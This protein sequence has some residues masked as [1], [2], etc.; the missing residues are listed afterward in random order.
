MNLQEMRHQFDDLLPTWWTRHPPVRN[1]DPKDPR[2]AD[3]I[4]A[5]DGGVPVT[6]A[7]FK[8]IPD[9]ADFVP[10]YLWL[11]TS[12]PGADASYRAN[13]IIHR[14]TIFSA[15][16]RYQATNDPNPLRAQLTPLIERNPVV[17]LEEALVFL[18]N[19]N[20][21]VLNDR[22]FQDVIEIFW[23][24]P[25][26]LANPA[27]L[28]AVQTWVTDVLEP[29]APEYESAAAAARKRAAFSARWATATAA[30]TAAREALWSQIR[31]RHQVLHEEILATAWNPDR[32][33]WISWCCDMDER[34]GLRSRWD[35][36][37]AC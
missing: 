18:R 24:P 36:V 5:R 6:A 33:E 35:H 17:T 14:R 29:W 9:D 21:V 31:E 22:Q 23:S 2:V 34:K 16:Q 3:Y 1:F 26:V 15:L 12:W 8:R 20:M 19:Q 37:A 25:L 27:V 30:W 7:V 10:F 32:P 13:P 28:S 11:T 4:T